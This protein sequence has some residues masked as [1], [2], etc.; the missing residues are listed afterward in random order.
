MIRALQSLALYS[1]VARLCILLL[2]EG[3]ARPAPTGPWELDRDESTGS[4]KCCCSQRCHRSVVRTC[5]DAGSLACESTTR[6]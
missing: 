4:E 1:C 5:E 2:S 3:E 6:A